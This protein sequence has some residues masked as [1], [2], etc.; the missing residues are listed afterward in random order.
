MCGSRGDSRPR[1]S[2]GA[3]LR[4]YSPRKDVELRSTRQPRAAVSTW[5]RNDQALGF[6]GEFFF[7]GVMRFYVV[8]QDLDELGDDLVALQ[9]GEQTSVHVDRRFWFLERSGQ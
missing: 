8:V 9:R 6:C 2:G 4:Y 5:F 3:T 7:G 1:L